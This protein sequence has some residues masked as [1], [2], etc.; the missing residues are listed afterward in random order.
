MTLTDSKSIPEKHKSDKEK[1]DIENESNKKQL[2]KSMS[3]LM[4]EA[5]RQQRNQQQQ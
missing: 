1:K 3:E 4:T 5:E 2:R